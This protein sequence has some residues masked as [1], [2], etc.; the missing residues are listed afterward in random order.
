MPKPVAD[1]S[2]GTPERSIFA[3]P[4]IRSVNHAYLRE[5]S[6]GHAA[7]ECAAGIEFL[8]ESGGGPGVRL[9]KKPQK[10]G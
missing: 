9:K 8:D 3:P 10:G 1:R 7:C 4:P 5:P 6:C 2:P